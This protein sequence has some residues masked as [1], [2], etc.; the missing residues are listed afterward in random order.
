MKDIKVIIEAYCVNILFINSL[1]SLMYFQSQNQNQNQDINIRAWILIVAIYYSVYWLI[2]HII[3]IFNLS[4][5]VHPNVIIIIKTISCVVCEIMI[6][7][8]GLK[9]INKANNI[10]MNEFIV[11]AAICIMIKTIIVIH[12]IFGI[13]TNYIQV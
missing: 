1:L 10:I 7:V 5:N 2:Y 9:Q 3:N 13:I 8:Y 11:T 12:E 6:C 4:K